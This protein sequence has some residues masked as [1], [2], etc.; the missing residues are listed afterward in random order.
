MMQAD[1]AAGSAPVLT[2]GR[3]TVRVTVE[4]TA[5]LADPDAR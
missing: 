1:A 3:T 2:A 5:E 4:A